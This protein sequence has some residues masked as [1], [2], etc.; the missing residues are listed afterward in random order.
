MAQR[1]TSEDSA[2]HKNDDG[3]LVHLETNAA[4]DCDVDTVDTPPA[5][6]I[7]FVQSIEKKRA[8]EYSA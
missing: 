7:E 4:D 1:C 3:V 5:W 8:P 6:T 2:A